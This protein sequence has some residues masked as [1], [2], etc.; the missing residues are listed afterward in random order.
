MIVKYTLKS[1]AN[2]FMLRIYLRLT[3]ILNN[4]KPAKPPAICATIYG[5]KSERGIFPAYIN[6][7]E[8]AGLN[9]PPLIALPNKMATANAAPMAK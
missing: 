5:I 7:M 2:V 8:T 9:A 1:I 6:A 3:I 4:S